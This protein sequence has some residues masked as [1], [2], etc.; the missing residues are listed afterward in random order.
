MWRAQCVKGG[1]IIKSVQTILRLDC[2]VIR[3]A[4]RGINYNDVVI[5]C[6]SSVRLNC[7]I[8]VYILISKHVP[9]NETR[10]RLSGEAG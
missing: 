3:V 7:A 6:V 4:V 1:T 8:R 9:R 10:R 2:E 5:S